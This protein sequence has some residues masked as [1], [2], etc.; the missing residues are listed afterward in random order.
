MNVSGPR[1]AG[2]RRDWCPT[3]IDDCRRFFRRIGILQC[4]ASCWPTNVAT[5]H[6]LGA[7][8]C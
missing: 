3:K 2:C 6:S 5:C 7:T 1:M 8:D 4:F